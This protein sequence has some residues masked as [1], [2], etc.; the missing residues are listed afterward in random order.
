M[1]CSVAI[2]QC[3]LRRRSHFVISFF[4]RPRTHLV[5]SRGLIPYKWIHSLLIP[6]NMRKYV[7][8]YEYL[9]YWS[10]CWYRSRTSWVQPEVNWIWLVLTAAYFNVKISFYHCHYNHPITIWVVCYCIAELDWYYLVSK[11]INGLRLC[12]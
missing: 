7:K 1:P 3:F 6:R 12:F 10:M 5:Y 9:R 11:L 8:P 2:W 4:S